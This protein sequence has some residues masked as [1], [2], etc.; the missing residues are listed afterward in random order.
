[1]GRDMGGFEK[2]MGRLKRGTLEADGGLSR[3]AVQRLK[4]SSASHG[5][6]VEVGVREGDYGGSRRGTRPSHGGFEDPQGSSYRG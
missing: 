3:A 5:P 1:M 6:S 2:F 4:V